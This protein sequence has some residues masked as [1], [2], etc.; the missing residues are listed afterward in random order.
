M[1]SIAIDIKGLTKHYKDFSLENLTLQLHTE[2]ILGLVGEN[3]AGKST[4][5][6]LI[7]DAIRR[8]AGQVSVFGVDNQSKEFQSVKE[9]IGVVLDEICVPEILN[10]RQFGQ[11]MANTY[12]N[13]DQSAYDRWLQNFQLNPGKKIKDYSRGMTMK[14]SIAAALSHH[15]K[16]LLLDEATSG[17]DPMLRD[18]LLDVFADF[19]VEEGHAVLLSSHIVSDLEKICDYIAFLHRGKLA[20]CEEKDVLLDRFGLL[21][22]SKEEI[23]QVPAQA[24][25]GKRLNSYGVEALVERELAPHGLLV[26]R[27]TL[28]NIILY[29]A[30]DDSMPNLGS[31][32][33]VI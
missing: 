19:A 27:A 18:E 3:G 21:K 16:L 2:C 7:M 12:Q 5:I 6:R 30:R 15:A 29:L 25:H 31:K 22:C 23:A 32:E 24:I 10:A 33:N 8:D 13:W 9:D 20:L 1:D 4:T 28:E 14:L 17:L 26:E 11:I